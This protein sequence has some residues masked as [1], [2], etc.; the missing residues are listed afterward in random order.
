MLFITVD[1]AMAFW[2]RRLL[3]CKQRGILIDA[4][5]FHLLETFV[6]MVIRKLQGFYGPLYIK[7]KETFLVDLIAKLAKLSGNA[8]A[9]VSNSA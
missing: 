9:N 6:I 8:L 2:K 4:V 7:L 3:P 5:A 1:A